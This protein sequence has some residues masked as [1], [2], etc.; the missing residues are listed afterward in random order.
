MTKHMKPS[1]GATPTVNPTEKGTIAN[2][3]ATE[4]TVS[5]FPSI[6][7]PDQRKKTMRF[8]PEGTLDTSFPFGILG[9]SLANRCERY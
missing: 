1:K 7:N 3:P 8:S 9:Y 4:P 2:K 5:L 6:P